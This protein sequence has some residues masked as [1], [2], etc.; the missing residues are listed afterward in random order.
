MPYCKTCGTPIPS[1][2]QCSPCAQPQA[3]A[4]T[5]K[6]T[7]S[8]TTL[9]SAASTPGVIGTTATAAAAAPATTPSIPIPARAT[10]SGKFPALDAVRIGA[11]IFALAA[12]VWIVFSRDP[13]SWSLLLGPAVI[14]CVWP[15]AG[16]DG[17]TTWA[18]KLEG[19]L[20]AKRAKAGASDGKLAKFFFRPLYGG[21]AWIWDKGAGIGNSHLRAGVRVGALLYFGSI[22]LF[23]GLMV[24]YIVLAVVLAFLFLMLA[25]WLFSVANGGPDNEGPLPRRRGGYP[26]RARESRP[27]TDFFGNPKTDVYD[28][29]DKK[30]GEMRPTTDFFG[31][32]KVDVYDNTGKKVGEQRP[33]TDFFGSPKTDVYASDGS[34]IGESRP[35]TDFFGNPVEKHYDQAGNK[36]GE[37]RPTTDIFGNPVV[38]HE[39]EEKK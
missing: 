35:T 12:I 34:K 29:S 6:A 25:L 23:L 2:T 24:G 10:T 16:N 22:M 38:K 4:A 19:W 26:P 17:M 14:A 13:A 7:A 11:G 31:N 5:T 21:S 18:E 32:P 36:V 3:S 15:L 1:G 39:W 28:K 20:K 9:P 27:T 33:T 30:V 8:P 37:S